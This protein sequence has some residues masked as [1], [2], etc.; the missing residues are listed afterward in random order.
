MMRL[1]KG[2]TTHKTN[3]DELSPARSESYLYQHRDV[4]NGPI[5]NEYVPYLIPGSYRAF[6]S[7]YAP[8]FYKLRSED[9][10]FQFPYSQT[11]DE[12]TCAPVDVRDDYYMGSPETHTF[13]YYLNLVGYFCGYP[14]FPSVPDFDATRHQQ[15]Q[16]EVLTRVYAKANS[17]N[18]DLLID[19]SQYKQTVSMFISALRRLLSLANTIGA[20]YRYVS[21]GP[22]Y[23]RRVRIPNVDGFVDP[24]NLAGLWCE[25]RFGWRPLL[26]TL[27]G[28]IEAL[29]SLHGES[30]RVTYRAFENFT[31][32]EEK[33][34]VLHQPTWDFEST[35]NVSTKKTYESTFRGG[36][37][38]EKTT[39]LAEDLG[40]DLRYVPIALWDLI[41]FSFVVDRFITVGDFIRSIHPIPVSAFGGSW[42]VER[43]ERSHVYKCEYLPH[44][45]SSGSGAGYKRWTRSGGTERTIRKM[46]GVVRQT[47]DRPPSLPTLRHDWLEFKDLYNLIDVLFLAIQRV[48]PIR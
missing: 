4:Y 48:K 31:S 29:H 3:T 43:F 38:L 6:S 12:T 10:V 13:S 45:F 40:L 19:L 44:S 22:G 16:D 33:L 32:K 42:V 41:P 20:F 36:I 34:S 30:K 11:R 47:F 24:K 26:N 46:S 27:N 9:W 15:A 39:T 1:Y 28:V 18:A 35:L 14:P 21:R 7:L 5:M 2:P 25:M 17:S 8:Q 23:R 37:L